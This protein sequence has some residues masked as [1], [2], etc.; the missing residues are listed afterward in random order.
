[1]NHECSGR[2]YHKG[3]IKCAIRLLLTTKKGGKQEESMLG[4]LSFYHGHS[5]DELIFD[6]DIARSAYPKTPS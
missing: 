6:L 5:R 1:M 4:Y 3:C 2:V